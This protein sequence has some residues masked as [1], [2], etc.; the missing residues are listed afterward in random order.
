MNNPGIELETWERLRKQWAG[1]QSAGHK[2]GIEFRLI[3]DPKDENNILAID[4]VQQI[5]GDFVTETVQH[6]AGEAYAALGIAGASM[7]TLVEAYKRILRNLQT[8]AVETELDLVV[9]MSPV[10]VASGEI[11]GYAGKENS[12]VR[13]SLPV[14]YRHYYVLNALRE[15][16]LGLT[17]DSWSS[18]RTVYRSGELEFYFEY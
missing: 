2:L 14:N 15:K 4:V 12:D 6:T 9:T 8:Q 11:R 7:E 10:S 18:V 17:G 1:L 3:A 16:M 5:D 13:S